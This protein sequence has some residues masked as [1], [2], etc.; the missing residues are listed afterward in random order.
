MWK[1]T[2]LKALSTFEHSSD[3]LFGL[4]LFAFKLSRDD[5]GIRAFALLVKQKRENNGEV[6]VLGF[7]FP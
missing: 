3:E 4:Y 5:L 1:D 2:V 7:S 6:S